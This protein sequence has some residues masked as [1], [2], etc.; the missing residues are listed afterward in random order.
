MRRLPPLPALRAFEAAA[1][2][3][4]F[5][6]AATEL[7]LTPSAISH[8]VRVLEKWFERP[9]F[10]RT[11]RLVTLTTEGAR[12][13]RD[14]TQA[15]DLIHETCAVLRPPA[16]RREL[17]V[18]C[19]PSFA[20]KWLSP[21][22]PLFMQ[23][24]PAITLRMTS[25]AEPPDLRQSTGIQVAITYGQPPERAAVEVESLGNE[26]TVPMCAP[27]IAPK[28]AVEPGDVIRLPLIES[29]LNPV[30]WADWCRLNGLRL[31]DA[32]R[33]SFDRG[34]LAV[35]AAV[36][37]VGVALESVR[38]AEPELARGELVVLDGPGF[39]R[40]ERQTHFLC[41]RRS[42]RDHPALLAFRD[43]LRGQLARDPPPFRSRR[44]RVAAAGS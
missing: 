31:P 32:A 35:A 26:L 18:H 23:A 41:W 13:Q 10:V 12:L 21:R 16:Q 37:A 11:P 39:R 40:I 19:A 7:S 4:S 38:F 25:S 42:D 3:G 33:P 15:F 43:W 24:H 30:H 29:E 8:Q 34:A 22:I 5:A 1:R 36:D 6:Q 2:L 28:G 17:A 9:L 20:S 44:A 27:R 14:L